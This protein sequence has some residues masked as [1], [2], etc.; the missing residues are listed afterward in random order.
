MHLYVFFF[1]YMQTKLSRLH[2]DL[3]ILNRGLVLLISS[4]AFAFASFVHLMSRDLNISSDIDRLNRSLATGKSLCE[5]FLCRLTINPI[6]E[7]VDEHVEGTVGN[8][9]PS[10]D[11]FCPVW[12]VCPCNAFH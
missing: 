6:E 11:E 5:D 4:V 2:W 3:W 7:A 12:D 8:G 10:Q 9:R 1:G